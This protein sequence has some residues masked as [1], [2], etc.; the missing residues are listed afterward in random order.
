MKTRN[1]QI[2]ASRNWEKR[3]EVYKRTIILKEN[4]L[5]QKD[6]DNIKMILKEKKISISSYLAKCL[7]QL[8]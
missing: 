6:Y 5:S 3:N 1:S 8:L 7:K 2:R 4:E